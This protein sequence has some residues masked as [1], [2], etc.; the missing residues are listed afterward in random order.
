MKAVCREEAA[1][2]V[3]GRPW[4]VD[5][6][7]LEPGEHAVETAATTTAVSHLARTLTAPRRHLDHDVRRLDHADRLVAHLQ[8]QLLGRLGGHQAHE[9][10]RPRHELHDRR[11]TVAFDARHDAS[12]AVPGG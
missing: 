12:E 5:A 10:V 1:S 6:L 7:P 2:T 8:V 4:V 3:I 11:D 9:A